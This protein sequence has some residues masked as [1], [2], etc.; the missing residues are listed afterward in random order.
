MTMTTMAA[1]VVM[2]VMMKIDHNGNNDE[3][4]GNVAD[5]DDD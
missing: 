5:R 3:Y 2:M 4:A 1:A